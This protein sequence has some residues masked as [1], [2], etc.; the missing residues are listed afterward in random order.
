MSYQGKRISN[1]F[2]I[3]SLDILILK[4]QQFTKLQKIDQIYAVGAMKVTPKLWS[5]LV[6][7]FVLKLKF[8]QHVNSLY[9]LAFAQFPLR[10]IRK[11]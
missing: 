8:D 6:L 7:K 2:K 10:W 9:W 4:K 11:C 3:M 5:K 1:W